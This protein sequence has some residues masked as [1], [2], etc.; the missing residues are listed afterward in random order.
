MKEWPYWKTGSCIHRKHQVKR[1]Q[2][3][4]F[5]T[6]GW[7]RVKVPTTVFGGLIQNGIYKDPYSG[8][9]LAEVEGFQDILWRTEEM[10]EDSQFRDPWWFRTSFTSR[11]GRAILH[12]DGINY[13]AEVWLNGEKVAEGL[14]GPYKRFEF[15]VMLKKENFAA[16]K[17]WPPEGMDPALALG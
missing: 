13:R 7:Y 6:S 12:L 1:S 16:V 2:A 15:D 11:T 17:V 8:K 3:E 9:N 14:V 4:G 10:P 5:D